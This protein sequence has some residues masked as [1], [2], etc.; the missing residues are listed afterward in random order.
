MNPKTTSNQ[1]SKPCTVLQYSTLKTIG[2]TRRLGHLGQF[3][4]YHLLWKSH[5][6]VLNHILISAHICGN[7]FAL[8]FHVHIT[9][10]AAEISRS[11][12]FRGFL[13]PFPFS[14]VLFDVLFWGRDSLKKRRILAEYV[15]LHSFIGGTWLIRFAVSLLCQWTRWAGA[16]NS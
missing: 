1:S 6:V 8:S 4:E 15:E 10:F 14:I 16:L 3:N 7:Y 2:G 11:V 9:G 13:R 12:W 5:K